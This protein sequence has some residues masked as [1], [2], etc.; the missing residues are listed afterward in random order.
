M[1]IY[2]DIIA[3]FK[4]WKGK[5]VD[6]DWKYANQCVDYVKQYAVDIGYPITTSGNAKDFVKK[7][8]WKNWKPVPEWQVGDIVIFP[9]GT[10]WH[11]AVT[12]HIIDPII[13]VMEQNRDWKAFANNN[14]KNKWSA[15]NLGKYI[16]KWNEVYFRPTK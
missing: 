1:S 15:V 12:H 9:N 3:S 2:Q 10:Y 8:L 6:F 4:K 7:W 14:V 16:F 5:T 13:F 11:I